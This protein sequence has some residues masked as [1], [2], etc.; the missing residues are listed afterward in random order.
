MTLAPSESK[1]VQRA[2]RISSWCSA[3]FLTALAALT[4]PGCNLLRG[5][6]D[7]FAINGP[8]PSADGQP[9]EFAA[10]LF[11]STGARLL[12]GHQWTLTAN[13]SVFASLAAD[14]GKATQSINFL[15]YIWDP[16]AASDRL[17][18]ALEK[19]PKNVQCR[20]IAD[21]LGSP[22]FEVKVAPRL[23]KI[24]CEAR[25]FRPLSVHNLLERDHRRLVVIDGRIAYLGGFGVR[26][27]WRAKRRRF[28]LVRRTRR[29]L[30]EEWRD[31][32]L[33][34]VGP[35][36]NDVQRAFAQNWQETGG[37]LL[38]ASDLP[39]IKPDGEASVAFISSTASYLTDAERLVHLLIASAQKRVFIANAYFVPDVSLMR[40]LTDRARHGIEVQVIAPSNKNDLPIAA[41]GQRLLYRQLLGAG[42]KVYEYQPTMMHAKTLIIDDRIAAIGSLN[43][44]LLSLSRLEEAV[45]VVDDPKLVQTLNKSWHQD[46]IDSR[47]VH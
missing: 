35:V 20:V 23:A 28:N 19:R 31:D 39:A 33:R 6:R 27:D 32:N 2:M 41:I 26:D 13:G 47:Q 5:M 17:I 43:L 15:D 10:A 30:E 21:A 29:R 38:P 45:V 34:V 12:P 4:L 8:V 46:L 25:L 42:V 24:G 1:D 22:S 11:Q 18:D 3:C 36:V 37:A 16:G 9:E 14:I 40:L 44:N 7:S